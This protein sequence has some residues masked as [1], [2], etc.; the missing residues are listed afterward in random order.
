MDMLRRIRPRSCKGPE[1]HGIYLVQYHSWGG[2]KW[3]ICDSSPFLS[4][5]SFFA[6]GRH[7]YEK[8]CHFE[9]ERGTVDGQIHC[10]GCLQMLG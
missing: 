6:L 8:L 1:E 9:E 2:I 4:T 7:A 10:L 3:N 5:P